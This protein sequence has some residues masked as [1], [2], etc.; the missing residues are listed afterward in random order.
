MTSQ[1]RTHA[2][3]HC[4]ARYRVTKSARKHCRRAYRTA[5][6]SYCGDVMAQWDGCV[7]R[8]QRI[9]RPRSM[10]HAA[11]L[12]AEIAAPKRHKRK[13]HAARSTARAYHISATAN[14]LTGRSRR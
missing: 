6:C 5:V 1:I 12:V 3:P 8:Y 10:T 13:S 2:C 4:G 14:S 7:R 9:R 11:K